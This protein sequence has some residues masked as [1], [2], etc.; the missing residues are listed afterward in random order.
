MES[1]IKLGQPSSDEEDLINVNESLQPD[2][3]NRINP[4]YHEDKLDK[5]LGNSSKNIRTSTFLDRV[6]KP[7]D[8]KK[9]STKKGKTAI[10]TILLLLIPTLAL[11]HF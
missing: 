3:E 7:N 10:T 11:T 6:L 9:N 5:A 4:I 8:V 2:L 1:S